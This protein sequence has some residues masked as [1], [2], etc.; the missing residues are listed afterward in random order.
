MTV[1]P[2]PVVDVSGWSPLEEAEEPLGARKKMWMSPGD[3]SDA[4][5]WKSGRE[6]AL[7]PEP[8]ADL[9]AEVI[10][11][12]VAPLLGVPA[13]ETR[14]AAWDDL[15]GIVSRRVAEDLV[16]GNELL[17][18]K[19][20]AYE[21]ERTG[22]VPGY[23]LRGIER[24]LE[25]YQG[26]EPGLTAF[27][28]FVGL[29]MFDGLI[30]NTDRH[31]ENWAVIGSLGMLAPSFDHGASLGFNVPPARR[32]DLARVARGGR[33][34]HFPGKPT[35]VDLALSALGAVRPEVRDLWITRVQEL[36]L[37]TIETVVRSLPTEWMSEGARTFVMELL[38]ENR[39]R[40][41]A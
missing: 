30:S 17:S 1:P 12:R 18:G 9:W 40:L 41:L 28:S 34:R 22:L 36:D 5:L 35:P 13:A 33:A 29:L 19:D 26:A 38:R 11:A 4:W 7:L 3:P 10:A 23:D 25:G 6:A 2:I 32:I 15:H 39:R 37:A 21:F 24:A 31:H 16:H 14:L 8:G 20:P 27:E